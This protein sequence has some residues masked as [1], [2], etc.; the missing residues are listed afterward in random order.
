LAGDV[1]CRSRPGDVHH[2][3][4]SPQARPP[5]GNDPGPGARS[6]P[7]A[8]R[9]RRWPLPHPP[10]AYR[11]LRPR[12]SAV[13]IVGRGGRGGRHGLPRSDHRRATPRG[14]DPSHAPEE[15]SPSA[16][17]ARGTG[18]CRKRARS[19]PSGPVLWWVR[20]AIALAILIFFPGLR[21]GF[22]PS[23]AE[24]VRVCGLALL[25]AA[26]VAWRRRRVPP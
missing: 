17:T 16:L 24:A 23:K 7:P 1:G 9:G 26:T 6:H 18:T 11:S 2:R 19:L 25:A 14:R 20:A 10:H 8:L 4:H 22:E 15:S 13:R 21:E 3:G 12:A 5:D